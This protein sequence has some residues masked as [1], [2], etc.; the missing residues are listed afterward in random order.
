MKTHIS[1]DMGAK[2]NGVFLAHTKDGKIIDKTATNYIFEP[3]FINFLKKVRTE[4]RHQRRGI[5]RARLA[6]RLLDEII[7]KIKKQDLSQAE[8]ELLYGLLKNRGFN[9]INIEFEDDLSD[10]SL[11]ILNEIDGYEFKNCVS[12]NDYELRLSE[13][14][15]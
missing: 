4:K 1:I 9:Y 2:N 14:A 12:K 11:E 6:R 7:K 5:K 3:S 15:N 13:I 10:E 8:C